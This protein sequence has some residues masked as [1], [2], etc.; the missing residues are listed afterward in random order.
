[1]ITQDN[2]S[3]VFLGRTLIQQKGSIG[4]ARSVFVKLQGNKNQ[5]VFPTFGGRVMNPFKGAAKIFAG[6]L[7]EYRTDADGVKPEIYLLKTYKVQ[8]QSGN[9]VNI[10]RD[11]YKHIP[12][13]GDILMKAPTSLATRGA[14]SLVS[15]VSKTQVA[16]VDV[17]ALTFDGNVTGLADG[18]ILIEATKA[19]ATDGE[20]VV[21]NIN[22]VAACDYDFF[23]SPVA[24][25]DSGEDDFESARYFMTPALGGLMYKSKMSPVPA[26]AEVYNTANVNGWFEVDYKFPKGLI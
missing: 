1:M 13:V 24:D 3:G 20:S 26:C 21:K 11:G 7:I 19:H 22:A 23:Y 18:D 6:D 5:L 9:T 16:N 2:L 12:F 17:W 25:P 14:A 10:Y 8:S 15:A 4:G